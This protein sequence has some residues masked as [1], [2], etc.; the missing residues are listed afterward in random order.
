MAY[1]TDSYDV[2]FPGQAAIRITNP[3]GDGY[4]YS[5][6]DGDWIKIL[7]KAAGRHFL[8]NAGFGS[9]SPISDDYIDAGGVPEDG[10]KILTGNSVDTDWFW[11][12]RESTTRTKLQQALGANKIVTAATGL[13]PGTGLLSC[14]VYTVLDFFP[15][16]DMVKLRNPW[17][18][19][20]GAAAP[21][22]TGGIFL[23]PLTD[24]DSKF[25][26]IGYEE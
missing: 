6:A 14:H 9:I 16:T 23:I 10:I 18:S 19:F 3:I 26:A 22:G 1:R 21:T 7:E 12:T 2:T 25:V 24:F 4:N 8:L 17:G 5:T 13:A 11:C 15:D 20:P